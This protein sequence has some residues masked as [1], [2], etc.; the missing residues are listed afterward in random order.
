MSCELI[1]QPNYIDSK[2]H[3]LEGSNMNKEVIIFKE[4]ALLHAWLSSVLS[5]EGNVIAQK[6]PQICSILT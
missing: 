5:L 2:L 3:M 6:L 1:V 4:V